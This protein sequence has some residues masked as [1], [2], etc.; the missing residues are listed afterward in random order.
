[1]PIEVNLGSGIDQD[2]SEGSPTGPREDQTPGK[3]SIY[4]IAMEVMQGG[5]KTDG[6]LAAPTTDP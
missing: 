3:T 6:G 4:S 2:R 5:R 1:M